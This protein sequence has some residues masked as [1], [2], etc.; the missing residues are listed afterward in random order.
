MRGRAVLMVRERA[1]MVVRERVVA[2]KGGGDGARKGGELLH[3]RWPHRWSRVVG[4]HE[5]G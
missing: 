2:G 5:A 4:S 3:S 1:V